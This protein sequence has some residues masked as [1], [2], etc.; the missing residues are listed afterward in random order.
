MTACAVLVISVLTSAARAESNPVAK[1]SEMG[2]LIGTWVEHDVE[3][4][5]DI[6]GFG[7]KGE[8]LDFYVE[9]RYTP[10]E[11]FIAVAATLKRDGKELAG[12]HQFFG[13][14]EE[15]GNVRSWMFDNRTGQVW[16]GL[17]YSD[18][19]TITTK[20]AGRTKPV[21]KQMIALLGKEAVAYTAEVVFRK[22]DEDTSGFK[23]HKVMI[24]G[25]PFPMPGAGKENISKRQK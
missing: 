20:I 11:R 7:K 15:T 5:Q 13:R 16:Q 17:V 22:V 12:F 8:K 2:W 3:L 4:E 21:G 1:L 10:A 14:D 25:K 6:P 24:N 23:F 9:Y 18:G 19:E